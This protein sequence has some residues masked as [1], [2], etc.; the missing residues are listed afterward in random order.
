MR[1]VESGEVG[2]SAGARVEQF[3]FALDKA[4]NPLIM[5]FGNGPSKLEME[6][7]ELMY[8]YQFY[9]YGLVGVLLYFVY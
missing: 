1:L 8:T 9:R 3:L 7:V 6:Y 4:Q 2:N 5:F